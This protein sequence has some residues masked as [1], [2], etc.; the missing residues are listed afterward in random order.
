MTRRKHFVWYQRPLYRVVRRNY[1]PI[2]RLC[3][4]GAVPW[5]PSCDIISQDL[6]NA[7]GWAVVWMASA[8]D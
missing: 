8:A 2:R 1:L 6:D 7:I 4:A 3:A 5:L